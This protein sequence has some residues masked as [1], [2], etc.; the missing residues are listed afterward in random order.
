MERER[1][2]AIRRGDWVMN[3]DQFG[4]IG[5]SA[6]DLN[7]GDHFRNARHDLISP[8]EL[9]AKI[10]QFGDA[11]AVADEFEELGRDEGEALGMIKANAASQSFLG[12]KTCVMKQE[13]V[14]LTRRQVHGY[15]FP[16]QGLSPSISS[17]N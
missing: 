15:P 1:Q 17:T 13:F 4:A 5:K 2:V 8:K 12:K 6:F 10:H 9:P 16:R 7:L 3:G 14:Y 11:F